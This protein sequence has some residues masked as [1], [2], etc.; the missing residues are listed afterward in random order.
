MSVRTCVYNA[1]LNMT[2]LTSIITFGRQRRYVN[3]FIHCVRAK[4]NN[5]RKFCFSKSFIC[6]F[7]KDLTNST[8]LLIP[9]LASFVEPYFRIS[10]LSHA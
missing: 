10:Y 1:F 5:P 6:I 3:I 7:C 4:H 9:F 8:N 2:S